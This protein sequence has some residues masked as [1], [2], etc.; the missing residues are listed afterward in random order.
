MDVP[1]ARRQVNNCFFFLSWGEYGTVYSIPVVRS[2][3]KNIR[4]IHLIYI[5]NHCNLTPL[6]THKRNNKQKKENGQTA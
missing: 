4:I 5:H 2:Q 6:N 1:F 3:S